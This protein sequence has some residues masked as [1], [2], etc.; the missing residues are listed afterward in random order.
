MAQEKAVLRLFRILV[1]GTCC[2]I[3]QQTYSKRKGC[4]RKQS[5][6]YNDLGYMKNA[7]TQSRRMK[8]RRHTCELLVQ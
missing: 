3:G 7:L 4:L 2:K 8:I 1:I 6:Q 5:S